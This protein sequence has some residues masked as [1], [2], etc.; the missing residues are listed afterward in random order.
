MSLGPPGKTAPIQDLEE[1]LSLWE[2]QLLR[3]SPAYNTKRH[4]LFESRSSCMCVQT[5][6]QA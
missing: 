2:I 6:I 4:H 5:S 1:E 3:S